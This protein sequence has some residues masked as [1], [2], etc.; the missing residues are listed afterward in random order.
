M[1]LSEY[2]KAHGIYGTMRS[3]QTGTELHFQFEPGQT[4]A[5]VHL[6]AGGHTVEGYIELQRRHGVAQDEELDMNFVLKFGAVDPFAP[7]MPPPADSKRFT[8]GPGPNLNPLPE[9]KLVDIPKEPVDR[10]DPG[11]SPDGLE[12]FPEARVFVP[13]A[14]DGE[15]DAEPSA[16]EQQMRDTFAAPVEETAKV[17]SEVKEVKEVK[18]APKKAGKKSVRR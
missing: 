8:P 15:D 7:T 5:S 6:D 11:P 3:V 1:K 4:R 17:A 10:F 12:E 13:S 18:D 9:K 2:H 16:V 14:P